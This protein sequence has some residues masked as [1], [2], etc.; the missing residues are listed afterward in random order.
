MKTTSTLSGATVWLLLTLGVAHATPIVYTY[1]GSPYTE[2]TDPDL[3]GYTLNDRLTA[4][5]T[6]DSSL[7]G[8]EDVQIFWGS[9]SSGPISLF[10]SGRITTDAAG[11]VLAWTLT[12]SS[13]G[14]DIITTGHLDGSGV[15]A[16]FGTAILV[17]DG[18]PIAGG[19]QVIYPLGSRIP[20][21]SWSFASV[22]DVSSSLSL[23]SLS[24]IPL[25]W[26]WHA[27][28]KQETTRGA[29][30]VNNWQWNQ[31]K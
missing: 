11:A 29:I 27:Q 14:H 15:D 9:V 28:S 18:V 13:A 4:S 19:A 26:F 30:G 1:I 2:T 3:P 23:L 31:R 22:P 6:I 21:S 24:L 10:D 17:T 20:G 12:G 25:L 16:N 5:F 8:I 7:W